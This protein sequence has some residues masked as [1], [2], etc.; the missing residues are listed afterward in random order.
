MRRQLPSPGS[1]PPRR[2]PCA[3]RDRAPSRG[4]R[5]PA[6]PGRRPDQH[7]A[8]R[9][10]EQRHVARLR[11]RNLRRPHHGAPPALITGRLPVLRWFTASTS[12][13][14]SSAVVAGSSLRRSPPMISGERAI[15]HRVII[16]ALLIGGEPR[17]ALAQVQDAQRQHVG[18]RPAA[19]DAVGVPAL[20]PAELLHQQRPLVPEVVADPPEVGV[21]LRRGRRRPAA[22]RRATGSAP[23]AG[24]WRRWPCAPLRS[25]AR[26]RDRAGSCRRP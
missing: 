14:V 9:G 4:S 13:L 2:R 12:S 25:R 6:R 17:G 24:R 11:S 26:G 1:L 19:G 18:V 15:D 20:Q 10:V 3:P 7:L 21:A 22:S 8:V 5:R 16:G 23:S